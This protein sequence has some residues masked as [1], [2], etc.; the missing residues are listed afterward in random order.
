MKPIFY[1]SLGQPVFDAHNPE[2]KCGFKSCNCDIPREADEWEE[3][4]RNMYDTP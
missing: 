4:H 1:N 2:A 3:A